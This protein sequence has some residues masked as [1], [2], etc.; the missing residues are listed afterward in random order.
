MTQIFQLFMNCYYWLCVFVLI[1]KSYPH[2]AWLQFNLNAERK[3]LLSQDLIAKFC[4]PVLHKLEQVSSD[5][6][7]GTLAENLL[8]ALK[9]NPDAAKKVT[10]CRDCKMSSN[11]LIKEHL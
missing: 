8:D 5:Q 11:N 1:A 9:T 10:D 7:V 6:H 3:L 2:A 4:I